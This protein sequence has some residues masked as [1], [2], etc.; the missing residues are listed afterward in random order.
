MIGPP[1]DTVEVENGNVLVNGQTLNED[2]VL[3]E[4]RDR[5]SMSAYKVAED[6]YFVLGDHRSSFNDSR[7]WGG[8]PKTHI[9]GKAVFVNLA[10]DKVGVLH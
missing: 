8:V 5:N 3:A 10:L 2:Y 1:G 9:Y 7:A 6:E 4:N